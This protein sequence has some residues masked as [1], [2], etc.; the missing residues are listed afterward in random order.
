MHKDILSITYSEED[1]RDCIK[2]LAAE[3][4]AEYADK[5]PVF[6]GILKGAFVFMADL[7]REC[8][9]PIESQFLRASSYGNKAVTSGVVNISD[10]LGIDVRN[11]HVVIVEDI[12]D[13][14]V[15]LAH[16]RSL[17][18][19]KEPASLKICALLDKIACRRTDIS[20]DFVGFVCEPAFFVGYGL[21]YAERYRNMPYIGVLKPEVYGG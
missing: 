8:V 21:D 17:L 10:D 19:E 15:T 20:G 2:R 13:T 5:N 11:R 3:L 6:I 12:L 14:G 1:I 7:M 16:I 4:T 18:L 9:F